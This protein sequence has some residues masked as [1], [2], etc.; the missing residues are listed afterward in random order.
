MSL[1]TFSTEKILVIFEDVPAKFPMDLLKTS[2]S[3]NW[4][5]ND[6]LHI[7][8]DETKSLLPRRHHYFMSF[9]LFPS[10]TLSRVFGEFLGIFYTSSTHTQSSISPFL[11][12]A[13]QPL[14]LGTVRSQKIYTVFSTSSSILSS[15]WI[16]YITTG[17]VKTGL[18]VW[19]LGLG[20]NEMRLCGCGME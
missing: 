6:H 2:E 19:R 14:S 13:V 11:S 17:F 16:T 9:M 10:P 3:E 8:R 5:L 18:V 1:V 12:L 15:F 20:W 7:F 4:S